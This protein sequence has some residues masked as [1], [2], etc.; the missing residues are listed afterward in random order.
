MGDSMALVLLFRGVLPL[1]VLLLPLLLLVQDREAQERHSMVSE[2]IQARGVRNGNVLRAMR[3]T[4]RHLFV[5][6]D[7][8][9]FAYEDQ[10]L[11]IGH[12][13]TIS[14]PYVVALMTELLDVSPKDRVLE[15]GTGS[16]YQAAILAQLAAEVYSIEIV[17]ELARSAARTLQELG[18]TNVT[19][20][21]GDGYRGW[22]EKSP[23]NRIILTAA[24]PQIPDALISQLSTGGR[25]VA[26][27]GETRVQALTVV[28]KSSTGAIRRRTYGDVSFV[29]M[30]PGAR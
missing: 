5:P 16:G 10:A 23:F 11:P 7:L 19:V 28:D 30:R 14:Q 25:L 29:P 18:Y 26:P 9:P 8:R 4:P 27:V 1:T 21:H 2:Q 17:P 22:P 20:R 12:Q 3:S 13:A 24:P 15:V 6:A